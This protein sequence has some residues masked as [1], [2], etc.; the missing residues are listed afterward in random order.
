MPKTVFYGKVKRAFIHDQYFAFFFDF[1]NT[2]SHSVD[3]L[4]HV[5]MFYF[6]QIALML[7][8]NYNLSKKEDINALV[9]KATEVCTA[10]KIPKLWVWVSI[11]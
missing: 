9:H 3:S 5:Y 2:I 1:I 10:K 6:L 7:Q 11:F 8:G 4:L